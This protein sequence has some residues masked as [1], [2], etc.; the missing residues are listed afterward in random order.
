MNIF[1][2]F[3]AAKE[4]AITLIK[5]TPKIPLDTPVIRTFHK[6]LEKFDK[7]YSSVNL[8]AV[9]AFLVEASVEVLEVKPL[10]TKTR[11]IFDTRTKTSNYERARIREII[12]FDVF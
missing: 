5:K 6:Y 9:L 11:S 2:K 12:G 1:R 3:Y 10:I 4:E 8:G 7:T